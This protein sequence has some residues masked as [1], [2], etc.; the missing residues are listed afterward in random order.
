MENTKCNK[1]GTEIIVV[2]GNIAA[3]AE[4]WSKAIYSPT[5][6]NG[7]KS[8]N[9]DMASL[10]ATLLSASDPVTKDQA[11]AFKLALTELLMEKMQ[12]CL[13][14]SIYVDY[15]PDQ[16]LVD[17][18]TRAGIRN[19]RCFPWKTYMSINS[20]RVEVSAGY[21]KPYETIWTKDN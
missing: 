8:R 13:S 14:F 2:P 15:H 7:D 1:N 10:L 16:I 11:E 18:A 20:D 19:T 12:T 9:G 5:F 6:D 17:A 21:G 3:A 4:W